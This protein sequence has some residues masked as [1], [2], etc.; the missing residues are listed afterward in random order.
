M[1]KLE[2]RQKLGSTDDE[3][4]SNLQSV[5]EKILRQ[6]ESHYHEMHSEKETNQTL[7]KNFE[8]LKTFATEIYKIISE[9]QLLWNKSLFS[10]ENESN[11]M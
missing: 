11:E 9:N 1:T 10:T 4:I 5:F 8:K 3:F 6:T 2:T 7:Q